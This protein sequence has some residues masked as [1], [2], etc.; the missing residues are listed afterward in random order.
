MKRLL[1]IPFLTSTL[2]AAHPGEPIYQSLCAACHGPDGKGVGEGANKFPPLYQSDWVK[3]NPRRIIQVVLNGLQGPVTVNGKDYNLAMPPHGGSM[4]DK[5]I[6]DVVSYVRT[7]LGNKAK[8]INVALVKQERAQKDNPTLPDMWTEGKLLKKYPLGGSKKP[9]I[10]D[11]LSYI[12]HGPFKSLAALRASKPKNA[13]EEKGGL[14]SLKHADKK[15][16]FGLVW[17][18]WLDV[19]K[20]GNYEF[21]YDTDDG[22]ALSINGKEIITRD[23]IGPFGKA[24]KKKIALKKGRAEI[25]IEYFEFTGQEGISLMWNGPGVK[26]VALSEGARKQK[27]SNPEILLVA[28]A[29]EATIYRNFIEGTDPRAIGVGYS[30]GVNLAFSGDSMS[31]DMI[32]TGKFMDAGRHWTNRGQGFQ[33][34]AGDDVV[35]VNRGHAFAM[36]ESQTETWPSATDNKLKATFKG[37]QLNKA[38]QPTFGYQFGDI[39]ISDQSLPGASAK[40][41]TR[42]ITL[43]VPASAASS[44]SLYFRA[45]SGGNV[46]AVSDRE[47]TFDTLKVAVPKSDHPPF[48]RANELLIPVPLTEGTHTIQITY[49]WN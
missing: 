17:T 32:W 16:N 33:P 37:Y 15:E 7:N 6:A 30:E 1:A 4:T 23:R 8:E 26:N 39:Q 31:L 48:V 29:G 19:P 24:S 22:G 28:P 11:L 44:D 49:T 25:K 46:T 3:G 47:F 36:L 2:F 5:Q 9:P 13:E 14:I 34:P 43:E 27:A 40:Q 42:T 41:F 35:T 10:N 18:G 12:H 21:V 45:L 38:Q 20:D